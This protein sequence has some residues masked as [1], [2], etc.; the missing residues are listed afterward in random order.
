MAQ[1]QRRDGGDL[2]ALSRRFWRAAYPQRR[3]RCRLQPVLGATLVSCVW[4]DHLSLNFPT[5]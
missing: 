1:A 3:S 5:G 2:L 4:N